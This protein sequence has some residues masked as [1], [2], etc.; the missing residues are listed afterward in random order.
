MA[1][2]LSQSSNKRPSKALYQPIEK[3][4]NTNEHGLHVREGKS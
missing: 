4:P 1:T 3:L 2:H